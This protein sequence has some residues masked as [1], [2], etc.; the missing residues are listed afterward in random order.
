MT[1]RR[2]PSAVPAILLIAAAGAVV[3]GTAVAAP[4][5][6]AVNERRPAD[7][8]GT[9]E[10]VNTAGRVSVAGWERPEVEVTGTLAER[11]E[12]L[13]FT[14][15]GTRTL[16]RV[17]LRKGASMSGSG[18]AVLDIK[19]PS[20]STLDASTVSADLRVRGVAGEQQLATVRRRRSSCLRLRGLEGDGHH[21][22]RQ[23]DTTGKGQQRQGVGV[24]RERPRGASRSYLRCASNNLRTK[25]RIPTRITTAVPEC[26]ARQDG[27]VHRPTAPLVTGAAILSALLTACSGGGSSGGGPASDLSARAGLS[28]ELVV[29]AICDGWELGHPD[30]QTINS[31]VQDLLLPLELVNGSPSLRYSQDDID[32]EVDAACGDHLDDPDAFV[33]QVLERLGLTD[34]DLESRVDA[35]CRR[36]ARQQQRIAAG[37]WSGEDI[38]DFVRDIASERGSDVAALRSAISDLCD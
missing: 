18:D 26:L 17:V 12:R 14:R 5:T 36:Y 34:D 3:A 9:V 30:H 33:T 25:G 2:R 27:R 11:V 28:S 20:G 13:E 16:V 38:D 31:Y 7:P 24:S 1:H 29:E 15:S 19:V 6:R 22:R 10:I 35:A 37:D 21:H 8:R 23:H 4:A 32:A